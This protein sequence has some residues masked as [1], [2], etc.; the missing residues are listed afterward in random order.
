M[1]PP[2][3][4]PMSRRRSCR[5]CRCRRRASTLAAPPAHHLNPPAILLTPSFTPDEDNY[6]V[7][8]GT[9]LVV[10]RYA[11]SNNQSKY[12]VDG[13]N[14]S[15]TEVGQLLRR[16]GIDLDNNRFLILQVG[17]GGAGLGAG[18]REGAQIGESRPTR[19]APPPIRCALRPHALLSPL[20]SRVRWSRSP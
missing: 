11:Y 16:R 2:P 10:A 7:V 18:E 8:P 19:P 3:L 20:L 15:F 1:M 12:T 6:E 9:E 4:L 13:K 17:K 14:S 5:R